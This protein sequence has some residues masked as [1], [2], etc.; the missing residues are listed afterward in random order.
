[1]T[2]LER[3][4][5][6]TLVCIP[7]ILAC[8]PC[9]RS[10]QRGALAGYTELPVTNSR[11]YH[12]AVTRLKSTKK[13]DADGGI[14]QATGFAVTSTHIVTAGHFCESI[15]EGID[16]GRL[17]K[18]IRMEGANYD[19]THYDI[20]TAEIV[21]ISDDHDLCLL[22]ADEEHL[23]DI[24]PILGN[25]DIL[26]TEDVVTVIGAPK[27]YFPVRRTG[28]IISIDSP[29]FHWKDMLFLGIDIQKGSSGSPVLWN[30]FVVGVIAILPYDL[31]DAALAVR[32]DHLLEFLEENIEI[33]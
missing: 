18:K 11:K 24:L 2:L 25:M 13:P 7:L 1:M 21:A 5:C 3:F 31:H 28:F 15:K 8:S 16:A 26:E 22:K 33:E 32:G 29:R 17:T 12:T 27:T 10:V 9:A 14:N 6:I 23:L 19:G 30:G 20:G 4:L